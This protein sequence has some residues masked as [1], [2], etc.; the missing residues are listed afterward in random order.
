MKKL[1]I[2]GTAPSSIHLAPYNNPDYEIWGLN[3]VYSYIDFAN[4]TNITRWFDIHS[5]EAIR[6]LRGST[7]EKYQ[8][9]KGYYAWLQNLTI[10]L[11]NQE[12]FPDFPTSVKYP[13][14]EILARFHRKYFTNTVS[15]MLAL[16]IYEGYEDISIFGVD[17]AT[18]SEYSDQR[19]SCEYFIGYA[20]GLGINVYLPDQSD[21]LKTPFLYGFED[22]KKNFIRAKLLA[23]KQELEQKKAAAN[24]QINMATATLNTYDGALQ[25]VDYILGVWL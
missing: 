10:P 8:F 1:A 2:V 15:W 24:Q 20:E 11:Y 3:G 9:G 16:A 18:G 19:P 13:L 17:M 4:I 21:L 14:E 12:I 7:D 6:R 5:M 22:E 23:R 25:D